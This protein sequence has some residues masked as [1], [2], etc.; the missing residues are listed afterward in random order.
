VLKPDGMQIEKQITILGSINLISLTVL[1]VL[2]YGLAPVQPAGALPRAAEV[3]SHLAQRFSFLGKTAETFLTGKSILGRGEN[4]LLAYC[5]P[6]LIST[7]VFL[8]IIILLARNRRRLPVTTPRLLFCWAV[9]FAFVSMLAYPIFAQDFWNYAAKGR[10][11]AAGSNPYHEDLT[12]ELAAGLPLDGFGP[13]NR[14]PHRMAYGPLWALVAGLVMWLSGS[15]VW[16]A[17]LLLKLVLAGAWIGCLRLLW[18]VLK[19]GSLR[20]QSVAIAVFGWLPLSVTQSLGEGHNDVPM[21]FFVLLWLFCLKSNR[22][23]FGSVSLALSVLTKYVTAPLFFIDVL[24]LRYH[25]KRSLSK[26]IPH[27]AAVATLMAVIFGLFYRSTDFFSATA[28]MR[29]WPSFFSPGAA[30]WCIQEML[31]IQLPLSTKLV[32][33]LFPLVAVYFVGRYYR[34]PDAYNL[35]TAVLAVLCAVLFG[36]VGHIW[37]WYLVW[38]LGPAAAA[39][40]SALTRWVVGVALA[41]PFILLPSGVSPEASAHYTYQVPALALYGLSVL[42]FL[43]APREWFPAANEKGLWQHDGRDETTQR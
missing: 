2:S 34:R 5:L 22:P 19:D 4:F 37:P 31:G 38:L 32:R 15:G 33:L 12:A 42:W 25:Q 11:V 1:S 27:A 43:L 39:S 28:A 3:F 18:L 35:W 26:Y 14:Y 7:A 41:M 6:L 8:S 16:A 9:T 21:L 20:S 29:K 36:V 24:H 17:G 23:L 30:V 40:G 13:D 10:M